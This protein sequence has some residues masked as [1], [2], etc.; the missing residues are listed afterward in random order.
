MLGAKRS[1]GFVFF[2]LN[3]LPLNTA[4]GRWLDYW[5]KVN[6]QTLSQALSSI[7]PRLEARGMSLL[8]PAP[9]CLTVPVCGCGFTSASPAGTGQH[10]RVICI[11]VPTWHFLLLSYLLHCASLAHFFLQLFAYSYFATVGFFRLFPSG[12]GSGCCC[13]GGSHLQPLSLG[14]AHICWTE[15]FLTPRACWC[16]LP[17]WLLYRCTDS[18][19]EGLHPARGCV[20]GVLQVSHSSFGAGWKQQWPDQGNSH[21]LPPF[22]TKTW[23]TCSECIGKTGFCRVATPPLGPTFLE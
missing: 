16:P 23:R 9:A 10:S 13:S 18:W 14:E 22:D 20:S 19:A 11:A 4:F 6:N 15:M 12:S 3:S 5:G 21:P 8:P 7:C 2:L 17:L 1:L